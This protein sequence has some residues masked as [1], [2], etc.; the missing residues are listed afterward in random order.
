MVFTFP[1]AMYIFL[2]YAYMMPCK[3]IQSVNVNH[4][5]MPS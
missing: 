4:G 5:A 3:I 2:K 1:I